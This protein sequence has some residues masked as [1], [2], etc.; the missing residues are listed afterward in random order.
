MAKTS[1]TVD[2]ADLTSRIT[3][4]P[5]PGSRKIYIE[6]S[7]PDIQVPFRE[8]TLTDTLVQEGSGEPRREANPPLRLYDPS[9]VYTD[10]AAPIDITRGLPPLRGAWINERADTEVL[11]GISSAYGRERLND[12]AL[13]ALRMAHAPVPRRA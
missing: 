2:T 8:V 6:G 13:A 7:R 10:P 1:L 12:P 9:G 4:T 3:R 11:P 5:F